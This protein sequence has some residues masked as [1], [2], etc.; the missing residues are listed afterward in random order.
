MWH[1]AVGGNMAEQFFEVVD[2]F[3][4]R[5]KESAKQAKKEKDGIRYIKNQLDMANPEAVLQ[6][7]N[8]ILKERLFKTYVGYHFLKELQEYLLCCKSIAKEDVRPLDVQAVVMLDEGCKN[9]KLL[10]HNGLLWV[11]F[12]N[13]CSVYL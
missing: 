8:Q 7:Y 1:L 4:F 10:F 11:Q 5:S 6:V 13:I 12:V 9:N 2:G 3:V